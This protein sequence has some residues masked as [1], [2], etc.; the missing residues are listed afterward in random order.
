MDIRAAVDAN[1]LVAAHHDL[2][3]QPEEIP[4]ALSVIAAQVDYFVTSHKD[5]TDDRK[6]TAKVKEAIPGIMLPPVF[7]REVTG[8]TSEELEAIRNRPIWR[9][10][11]K[12]QNA[13]P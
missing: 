3:R 9:V 4:I 5:F 2:V 12:Q 11:N 6:S 8:W 7:L 13:I 10:R 1:V